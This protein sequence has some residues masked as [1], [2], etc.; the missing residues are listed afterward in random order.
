VSFVARWFLGGELVGG[1]TSFK[2]TKSF[3]TLGN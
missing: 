2:R 3:I 1:E